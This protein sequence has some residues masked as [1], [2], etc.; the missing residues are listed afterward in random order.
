MRL[1]VVTVCLNS[2]ETIRD[3]IESFLGQTH[4]N[5]EL[6]IVDGRSSDATLDIARSFGSPDI[7]IIS[8]SDKG[9]FDAMNKG[10]AG[11]GGDAVGFLNADDTF[12]DKHALSAVDEALRDADVAFGDLLMVTDHRTK[13][14]VREWRAGPYGRYAFQLGW[15]P[16]HPGFFAR[17]A[18][19]ERTGPFDLSYRTASDYDWML[20]ALLPNDVRTAYIPR[21]LAD[22]QMGGVST[23]DWRATLRGTQ[24]TLRS[25]REH[26][27]APPVDAALF[28]RLAR[29]L[30]QVRNF[31]RYYGD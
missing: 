19:V 16:P 27:K 13:T 9:V 31:R 1:S 4:L 14:V 17:R 28:L 8:E 3:T 26:L 6:L 11:F 20:R 22:F 7:R 12:H 2:Q 18:V 25:R 10:L 21:L 23:R 15:Q 30:F 5:R 24:E 29:R